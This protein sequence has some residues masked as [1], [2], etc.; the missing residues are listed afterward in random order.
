[1]SSCLVKLISLPIIS[2]WSVMVSKDT[3]LILAMTQAP[4]GCFHRQSRVLRMLFRTAARPATMVHTS[5]AAGEAKV[6]E[7]VVACLCQ[8]AVYDVVSRTPVSD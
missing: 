5:D 4:P 3:F 1:M 6:D 8:V 2:S 7:V